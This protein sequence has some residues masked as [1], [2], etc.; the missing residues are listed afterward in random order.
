MYSSRVVDNWKWVMAWQ[1][2]LS[3]QVLVN[4]LDRCFFSRWLRTLA[5]WLNT[6]PNYD[7]VGVWYKGWKTVLPDRL[8][9]H[10]VVKGGTTVAT[11]HIGSL[12]VD[13]VIY[14][15]VFGPLLQESNEITRTRP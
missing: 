7:E 1:Q 11:A 10:P 13:D 6:A 8:I 2:V 14:D 3:D 12:L 4:L 15:C 9:G 5:N